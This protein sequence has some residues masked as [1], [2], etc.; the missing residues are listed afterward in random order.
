MSVSIGRI[1]L[2]NVT[3]NKPRFVMTLLAVV[4]SV[5]I[6]MTLDSAKRSWDSAREV[7]R[8]DR[9]V[10]RHKVTFVLPLPRRYVSRL[11]EAKAASG[12]PL[13]RRVTYAVW[14][15]GREP[16]HEHEFFQSIA[17]D[18]ESYFDVYDEVEL[19]P[20]ALS[21]FR[22]NLDAAIVGEGL[23]RK[24]DLEVGDQV[25]LESP[26]YPSADGHPWSFRVAGVYRSRSRAVDTQSF[27]FRYERLNEALASKDRDQ[28]GW[29]VSRTPPGADAQSTARAVDA[30]FADS[31]VQTV[32]Q[33]ERAFVS[34]FLGMVST[35]LD[36][37]SVL[38]YAIL[39]IVLLVLAN[40]LGLSVRERVRE[41]ASLKALGFSRGDVLR[42]IVLEGVYLSLIGVS[43]GIA[44]ALVIIDFGIGQFFEQNLSQFFPIFVVR[45]ET[46]LSAGLLSV[47]L[48]VLA[49][50]VPAWSTARLPVGAALSRLG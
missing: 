1:A 38:S 30:L 43:V 6:F 22:Q 15:G 49:G 37:V 18:A 11:T 14:F 25:S 31:D 50:F 44:V 41:Y 4:I 12:A 46:L 47:A 45:P 17:V 27:V 36:V 16:N 8:Q 24:L 29:L 2:R 39:V 33:D 34:G 9:L 40:A 20:E 7:S 10:T 26:I 28:V 35:V 23:A 3:R 42:L 32:T 13:V 19:T 5:L 21:D 48:G